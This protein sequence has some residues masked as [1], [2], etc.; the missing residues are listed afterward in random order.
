MRYVGQDNPNFQYFDDD[1]NPLLETELG[2]KTAEEHVRSR[3]WANKD[4][5]SWTWSEGLREHG[6]RH[7]RDE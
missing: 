7:R 3:Q 5:L 1:G 6:P 4:A 2:I